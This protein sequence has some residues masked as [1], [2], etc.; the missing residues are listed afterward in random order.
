ME[1]LQSG[2]GLEAHQARKLTGQIIGVMSVAI[3]IGEV[4]K[5]RGWTLSR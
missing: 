3:T 4:I 1:V 5:L 2:T